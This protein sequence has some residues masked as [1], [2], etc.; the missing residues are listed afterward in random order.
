MWTPDPVDLEVAEMRTIPPAETAVRT[1]YRH[2]DTAAAY[3]NER[4]VG[5]GIRRSSVGRAEIFIETKIC[6]V[7]ETGD[8]CP[9]TGPRRLVCSE[10]GVRL[11]R[12]RLC[13]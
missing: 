6:G 1:G 11:A 13:V 2:L 9:S 12:A 4:E 7:C 5:E 8:E 3:G 10:R